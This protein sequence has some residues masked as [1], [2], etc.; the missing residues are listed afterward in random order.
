MPK[1]ALGHGSNAGPARPIPGHPYHGRSTSELQFIVKDASDAARSMRGFSKSSESKYLDQVNDATTVL[2]YRDRGG[3][4]DHHWD[5]DA[6]AASAL[7]ASSPKSAPAPVH[8]AQTKGSSYNEHGSRHGYNPESV[9]S[10]IKNNRTGKIG[11]KEASA[12]H[13]LLKGR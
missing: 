12:I 8:E 10:A 2:G 3:M 11:R 1:D 13:R 6:N 5:K 9:N 7:K 4:S